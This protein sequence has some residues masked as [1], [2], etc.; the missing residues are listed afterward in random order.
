MRDK[1]YR[2][3]GTRN[4]SVCGYCLKDFYNRSGLKKYKRKY[5]STACYS[6]ARQGKHKPRVE[7]FPTEPLT[8]RHRRIRRRVLGTYISS[9]EMFFEILD[10]V[11]D[12][13][14]SMNYSTMGVA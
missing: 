9:D 13:D 14:I 11:K 6:A 12:P 2:K 4:N 1:K 7:T 3:S 8:L 5:C 10:A